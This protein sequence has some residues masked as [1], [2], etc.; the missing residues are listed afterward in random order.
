MND[1]RVVCNL[2]EDGRKRLVRAWQPLGQALIDRLRGTLRDRAEGCWLALGGPA[3]VEDRT[4]LEDAEIYLDELERLEQAGD[5]ADPAALASAL[6]ALFALPDL[7]AGER[8]Q[9]MTIHKA[10][11]LEFD[12]VIVPGLD[13]TPMHGDPP[14]FLWKELSPSFPH[15][16]SFPRRRESSLIFAPIHET[17]AEENRA[18]DYLKSLERE[19]EDLEAGRLLYVAVTRAKQRVH[20]LGCVKR[21]E[22]GA[23]KT[24]SKRSLLA[25]LWPMAPS[26]PSSSRRGAA[27]GDGEVARGEATGE[28]G[29]IPPQFLKRLPAAWARPAAPQAADC[30]VTLYTPATGAP[31]EFSWARETARHVGTVA[32]RW[33]QR[34]AEDSLEGW[35]AA[36]VKRLRPR[37]R[38]ELLQRGVAAR[39]LESA[40]ALVA[41][42]LANALADERGRWLLG[43]HPEAR[44]EYRVRTAEGRY[45]ID[46]TFTDEKGER[47]VADYK[48]GTHAGTDPEGF[49]ERERERYAAQL[50]RY[51]EALGGARRGLYFPLLKGW[52]EWPPR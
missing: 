47:W 30:K 21:D 43:P 50:D 7:E 48:T 42:A 33:L 51:A 13:R 12:T 15:G 8:L 24:P 28:T 26:F 36:R 16:P 52:R 23:P 31:V 41:E 38:A 14:L 19:A 3:C 1:D 20:L 29:A 46:R 39:E 34:I 37:F 5:I 18:Y 35:S 22:D 4:D 32:H 6:D 25:K 10:K 11:G 27:A 45:V 40:A 49:L 17:G 2:S 44:S 9:V